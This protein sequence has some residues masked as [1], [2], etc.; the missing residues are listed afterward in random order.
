MRRIAYSAKDTQGRKGFIRRKK[1][2]Y[3]RLTKQV[4]ELEDKVNVRKGDY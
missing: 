1:E 3:D 2:I 4:N